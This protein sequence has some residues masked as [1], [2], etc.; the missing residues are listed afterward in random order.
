MKCHESAMSSVMG[1]GLKRCS[2]AE[3]ERAWQEDPPPMALL[4]TLS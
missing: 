2:T 1:S 4:I 3:P